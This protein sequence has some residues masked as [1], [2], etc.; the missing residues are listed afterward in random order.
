MLLKK[1]KKIK[2]NRRSTAEGKLTAN[3]NV[4]FVLFV[5]QSYR[6]HLVNFSIVFLMKIAESTYNAPLDLGSL[7]FIEW[8]RAA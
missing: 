6:T 5:T 2:L 4:H 3:C 7:N 1:K 8:K